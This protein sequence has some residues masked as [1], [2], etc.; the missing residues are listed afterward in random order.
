MKKTITKIFAYLFSFTFVLTLLITSIDY[1]SFNK[2]FYVTEFNEINNAE[3][4][5][6]TEAE[7]LD[8]CF[9]VLDYIQ[10]D[11]DDMVTYA[12]ID[13]EYR[14]VFND[15]EKL[16]MVDVKNLYLNAMDIRNVSFVLMLVS[17]IG[18]LL[19][20]NR[21]Y[22]LL[23]DAY[24]KTLIIIV[25]IFAALIFYAL[26]DFQ[27]FWINFHYLFFDNDLWLLNPN[28]SIM[29]N[30]VPQQFF[31][32]LVLRIVAYFIIPI[33]GFLVLVIVYIRRQHERD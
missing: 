25:V 32:D 24:K 30:M 27:N 7:L 23:A 12:T 6:T 1:N 5:K 21:K 3:L 33:I 15:R 19:L 22:K 20:S 31:N 16:H 29:I 13:N 11:R 8:F 17:F 10:D 9:V 2:D 28:T 4:I 14:E 18:Y 26:I